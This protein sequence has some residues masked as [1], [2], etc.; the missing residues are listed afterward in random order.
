[1]A[2]VP[3]IWSGYLWF[4]EGTLSL[5]RVPLV[6]W[7][8]P[9]HGGGTFGLVALPWLIQ[10]GGVPPVWLGN[11]WFGVGTLGYYQFGLVGTLSFVGIP[12]VWWCSLSFVGYSQFAGGTVALVMASSL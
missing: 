12:L 9:L 8:Y 3:S 5:V 6:W 10:F 1:M 4:G 2:R 11:P 7:G